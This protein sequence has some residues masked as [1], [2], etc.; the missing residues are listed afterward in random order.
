MVAKGCQRLKRVSGSEQESS[1][2]GTNPRQLIA[3]YRA[4]RDQPAAELSAPPLLL[5]NGL[6]RR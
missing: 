1:Y 2:M 3:E 4:F 5:L 6:V